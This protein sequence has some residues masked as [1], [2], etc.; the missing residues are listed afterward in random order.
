MANQGSSV[1]VVD[2]G[3]PPPPPAESRDASRSAARASLAASVADELAGLDAPADQPPPAAEP[4]KPADAEPEPDE[5]PEEPAKPKDEDEEDEQEAKAE[6]DEQ[7]PEKAAKPDKDLQRRLSA[8]RAEEKRAKAAL[9]EE[10]NAV[11]A[12]R[13]QAR[14]EL[15][16]ARAE[17]ER[18]KKALSRFAADPVAFALEAGMTEDYFEDMARAYYAASPKGKTDPRL[19]EQVT[20]SARDRQQEDA[21]GATRRELAELKQYIQEQALLQQATQFIEDTVKAVSDETPLVQRMVEKSPTKARQR[22]AA[23]AQRLSEEH[24]EDP[25]HEDVVAELEKI[26][27]EELEELGIDVPA[28]VKADPKT[29]PLP[30]AKT[31]PAKTLSSDLRT[32]AVQPRSQPMSR[33]ERRRAD[34]EQLAADMAAGRLDA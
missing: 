5:A 14:S 30:A 15:A 25:D 32:Q 22:L 20:R 4:D 3:G 6:E 13:E 27:R 28:D 31:K 12:E 8:V 2:G 11:K 34:F 24:G 29:K 33:D 23:V 17:T 19:R 10:R 1:Q 9:A 21:L 26:R 7:E 18:V 16:Q